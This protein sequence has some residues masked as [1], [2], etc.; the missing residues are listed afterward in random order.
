MYDFFDLDKGGISCGGFSVFFQR[1]LQLFGINAF[2]VN[3]GI[4][5]S[6]VTH[7]TVIVPHDGNFYVL[8]PS[9]DVTF[10]REGRMLDVA[11][12]INILQ[13]RSSS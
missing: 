1:V 11:E 4:Q 10:M 3:Y 2:T 6:F 8:D 7:V 13:T 9:F 12:A 5:S